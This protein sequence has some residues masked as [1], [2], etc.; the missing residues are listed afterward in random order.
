MKSEVENVL[1]KMKDN[2]APGPDDIPTECLKALNEIGIENLSKL[3]SKIYDT[4]CFPENMRKS[5]FVTLSKKKQDNQLRR[6]PYH[7]PLKS[8]S[9]TGVGNSSGKDYKIKYKSQ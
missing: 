2:K 4:V 9:K 6:F 5:V 7:Q 3:Y 1:R 8:H